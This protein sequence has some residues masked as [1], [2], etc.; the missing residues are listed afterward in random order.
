[1]PTI[2]K[3]NILD[4]TEEYIVHQCNCKTFYPKGLSKDIFRKYPY[5]DDYTT[6]KVRIPGTI[7][8]HN[9]II[10][11][12]GQ[13]FPGKAK[14]KEITKKRLNWFKNGL[15]KIKNLNPK[16]IAF[17]F[18]IGCGLAGGTWKD[19]LDM[20]TAFEHEINVTNINA[21]TPIIVTIYNYE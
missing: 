15:D 19:Y 7:N 3:G 16:S 9:N 14:S 12:F 18:K 13:N 2:I 10:N 20:I 6:K 11:L 21:H 17:P 5:A 8:V 1:M 4:A